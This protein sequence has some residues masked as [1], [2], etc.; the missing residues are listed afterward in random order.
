MGND[1]AVCFVRNKIGYEDM[2]ERI[3]K[4]QT[5]DKALGRSYSDLVLT[6]GSVK[7]NRYW[8]SWSENAMMLYNC[9]TGKLV[10]CIQDRN[11]EYKIKIPKAELRH[12][13]VVNVKEVSSDIFIIH[14]WGRENRK[15]TGDPRYV[16]GNLT[17]DYKEYTDNIN[18][19]VGIHRMIVE[20]CANH[21]VG[22]VITFET[23]FMARQGECYE[24]LQYY[25][26]DRILLVDKIVGKY[27][28]PVSKWRDSPDDFVLERSI[29]QL[30]NNKE[31]FSS[32][33]FHYVFH[34]SS[35]SRTEFLNTS[36]DNVPNIMWT[37]ARYNK[38]G[39]LVLITRLGSELI[40]G[41]ELP[42]PDID[43]KI[44]RQDSDGRDLWYSRCEADV[45]I[46]D[47]KLNE[48][49]RTTA[50]MYMYHFHSQFV[51]TLESDIIVPNSYLDVMYTDEKS[52]LVLLK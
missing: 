8:I 20:S 3:R 5:R 13:T 35:E 14:I 47:L 39:Q 2:H 1:S 36:L 50:W 51:T 26:N 49:K 9:A 4:K 11:P 18:D 24:I 31:V 23:A 29:I 25:L 27:E 28:E 12:T 44:I 15:A 30:C 38:E 34:Y 41:N 46:M 48:I 37:R 6:N 22:S 42:I 17:E 19:N 7:H 43:G 40:K 10:A 32:N 21:V 52:K 45:I 16:V 33:H